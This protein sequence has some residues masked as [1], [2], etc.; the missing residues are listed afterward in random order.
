MVALCFIGYLMQDAFEVWSVRLSPGSR[1]RS[2]RLA[3]RRY[4][5]TSE[6]HLSRRE[7]LL[8]PLRGR[9]GILAERCGEVGC[10]QH[11]GCVGGP[12]RRLGIEAAAETA[13]D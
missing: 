4:G 5:I 13:A 9:M 11:V 6:G 2:P 8:A 10:P 7:Q 3:R 1:S 12:R